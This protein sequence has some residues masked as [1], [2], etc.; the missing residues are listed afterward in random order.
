MS[1]LTDEIRAMVGR[2]VSYTAPEELGR[3]SIRYFARAVGDDNPLYTDDAYARAHGYDGV[4]AP[5]TLICETNQYADLPADA[6]GYAGHDWHIDIPGA[7]KVRGGNTYTFHRPVRPDDVVTATWRLADVTE[8]RT[9]GGQEMLVVTSVATY[10]DQ[11]G[12]PLVTNE[13]TIIFVAIKEEP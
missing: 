8:R 12:G 6:D 10:T 4:I 5:P 1:L 13:E 11:R 9:S 2:E 7:R 3:A